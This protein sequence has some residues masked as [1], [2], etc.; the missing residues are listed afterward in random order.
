M[1][2]KK[3]VFDAFFKANNRREISKMKKLI[4]KCFL[5]K[6][7]NEETRYKK[8]L[9]IIAGSYILHASFEQNEER[10]VIFSSKFSSFKNLNFEKVKRMA[11]NEK[12]DPTSK[13]NTY[14]SQKFGIIDVTSL[15]QS[16]SNAT[17]ACDDTLE[18]REFY[19]K[20]LFKN[21]TNATT[22]LSKLTTN[23]SVTMEE[24]FNPSKTPPNNFRMII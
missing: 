7:G 2:I 11:G 10:V 13:I 15:E 8:L 19:K 16:N 24:K 22:I 4:K 9:E 1:F 6:G 20:Y 17:Q 3:L 5:I 23:N 12:I 18:D 21:T 14:D